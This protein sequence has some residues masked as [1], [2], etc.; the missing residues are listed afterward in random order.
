M[1]DAVVEI[2]VSW[3]STKEWAGEVADD[4]HALYSSPAIRACSNCKY[5]I[6]DESVRQL[7]FCKHYKYEI[8]KNSLCDDNYKP[9][10]NVVDIG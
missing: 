6:P 9:I 4:I 8:S 10:D 5:Y 7:G 3:G 1:R 2:L